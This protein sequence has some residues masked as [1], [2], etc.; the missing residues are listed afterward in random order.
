MILRGEG[1]GNVYYIR[2]SYYCD[3][4][5][6]RFRNLGLGLL[7][8]QTLWQAGN[9]RLVTV[10]GFNG[11]LASVFGLFAAGI[12]INIVAILLLLVVSTAIY[13]YLGRQLRAAGQDVI[14]RQ[15]ATQKL[16]QQES[17]STSQTTPMVESVQLKLEVPPIP[18][19]DL[20]AI[21]GI[22]GLDTFLPQKPLLIKKELFLKVICGENQKWF[23]IV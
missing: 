20:S 8:C 3:N 2:D 22:F 11:S 12:Y 15:R 13:I 21:K 5:I 9:L 18:E 6:S 23:I 14:L 19:E 7:S 17:T 10:S 4:P 1:F 16:A